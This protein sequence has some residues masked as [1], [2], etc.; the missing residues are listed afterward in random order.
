ML[1]SEMQLVGADSSSKKQD[2]AGTIRGA[3]PP[4]G[5]RLKIGQENIVDCSSGSAERPALPHRQPVRLKL[6]LQ[7]GAFGL[8]FGHHRAQQVFGK[9]T[10]PSGP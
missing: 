5:G 2:Q 3:L 9:G 1:K 4:G 7:F 10:F 8:G 6:L